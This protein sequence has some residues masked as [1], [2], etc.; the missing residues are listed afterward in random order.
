MLYWNT[1]PSSISNLVIV[2]RYVLG[3]KIYSWLDQFNSIV[4]G[5]IFSIRSKITVYSYKGG[6][7]WWDLLWL[8]LCEWLLLPELVFTIP[9][10]GQLVLIL[11]HGRTPVYQNYVL[12]LTSFVVFI[13][14]IPF[15]LGHF[16][17]VTYAT[18]ICC[19][20]FGTLCL[21]P[22]RLVWEGLSSKHTCN[23]S[24]V[25]GFLLVPLLLN[26]LLVLPFGVTLDLKIF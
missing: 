9:S 13:H 15:P 24:Y 14:Y 16:L 1:S 4:L 6:I 8:A 25:L 19:K 26:F 17:P 22:F 3:N 11:V 21:S 20:F 23:N 12:P 18:Y 2:S 10:W 5:S 7:P